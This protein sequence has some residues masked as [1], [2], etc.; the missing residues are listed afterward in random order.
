MKIYYD[1]INNEVEKLCKEY[2]NNEAV[3]GIYTFQGHDNQTFVVS[4]VVNELCSMPMI[5]DYR[6]RN[7]DYLYYSLETFGL[8]F[9][10]EFI[11]KTKLDDIAVGY[12]SKDIENLINSNINYDPQKYLSRIRNSGLVLAMINKKNMI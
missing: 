9:K 8:K 5:E 7:H 10:I 2:M 6:L 3:E 12:L 1:L 11:K 4:V